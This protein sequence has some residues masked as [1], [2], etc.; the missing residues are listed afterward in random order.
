MD[1]IFG[2]NKNFLFKLYLLP[3]V[4]KL[5]SWGGGGLLEDTC[6]ILETEIKSGTV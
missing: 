4:T 6:L 5:L 1:L 2:T 3:S